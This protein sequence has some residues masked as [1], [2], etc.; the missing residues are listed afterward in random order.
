M[1]RKRAPG[2]GRK[3]QGEYPGKAAQ[4]T[5]RITPETKRA[6]V[7]AAVRGGR[8]LSQEVEKR[9]NA[10]IMKPSGAP[11]NRGLALAVAY[12]AE[13]IELETQRDWRQDSFTAVGLHAGIDALLVR[14][15]AAAVEN[16][17]VPPAIEKQVST[18]PPRFAEQY[19][20]AIHFGLFKGNLLTIEIE[21]SK[22][23]GES[24]SIEDFNE[25][26][27]P[28]TFTTTADVLGRIR[29]NLRSAKEEKKS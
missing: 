15:A 21:K 11:H 16:P 5:T 18:M 26:S 4:F 22:A 29:R 28:F 17:E 8:S 2:G 27:V 24:Y 12:L 25:W 9:L 23:P 19:R 1:A 20:T 14:Y 13:S 7:E 10:T 3:P 6:L